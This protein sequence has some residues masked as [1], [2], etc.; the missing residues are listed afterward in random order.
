MR[1]EETS[2]TQTSLLFDTS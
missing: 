1:L 2:L